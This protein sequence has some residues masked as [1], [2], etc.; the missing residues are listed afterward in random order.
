MRVKRGIVRHRRHKKIRKLAKGYQG[1]G[2]STFV[3]AKERSDAAVGKAGNV[4]DSGARRKPKEADVK[5]DLGNAR[6]AHA[7]GE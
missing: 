6:E 4:E 2:H 7:G 3:K 1:Q 5:V